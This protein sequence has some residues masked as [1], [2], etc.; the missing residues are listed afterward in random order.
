MSDSDGD[1]GSK[2]VPVG[3]EKKK[4]FLYKVKAFKRRTLH[5]LQKV[6]ALCS[7]QSLQCAYYLQKLFGLARSPSGRESPFVGP[8]SIIR[9]DHSPRLGLP[10]HS[11]NL[12][13]AASVLCGQNSF[14]GPHLP[15]Q[16]PL[17]H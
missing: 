17:V 14:R 6:N 1:T 8:D 9:G 16:G 12:W 13:R 11:K 3:G 7:A 5:G 15:S 2:E 4:D 10:C